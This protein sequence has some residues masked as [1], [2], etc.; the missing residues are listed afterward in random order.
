MVGLKPRRFICGYQTH[1]LY[2]WPGAFLGA[3]NFQK[4]TGIEYF[5][6]AKDMGTGGLEPD[7]F[8]YDQALQV[9]ERERSKDP[10]FIFVFLGATAAWRT[11]ACAQA[12]N[13]STGRVF[14]PSVA[15]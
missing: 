6:D 10:L 3:R 8:F 15:E 1:T 7:R 13:L 11:G 5:I 4:S 9:I 12:G 2:P 14:I